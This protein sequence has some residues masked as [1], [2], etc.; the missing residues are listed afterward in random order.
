MHNEAEPIGIRRYVAP[1]VYF[2]GDGI[3]TADSLDSAILYLRDL[4]G[5]NVEESLPG[6]AC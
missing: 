4:A 3:L 1:G 6:G 2:G 5:P